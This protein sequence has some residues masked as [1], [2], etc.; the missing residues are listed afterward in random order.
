MSDNPNAARRGCDW[1]DFGNAIS[2]IVVRAPANDVAATLSKKYGGTVEAVD[3]YHTT[4]R[5]PDISRVV[6]QHA[7]HA[8]CVFASTDRDENFIGDLAK[9]LKTRVL[10]LQHED[11]AGWTEFRVFDAGENVETYS[12]G[13]DYADEMETMAEELGEDFQMMP[14]DRGK[15][16]DHRVNDGDGNSFFFRSQMRKINADDITDCTAML[17]DAFVA[18]DAWLPGWSHFPWGDAT[19]STGNDNPQFEKALRIKIR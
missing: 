17:N 6:F 13:P 19:K 3:P 10:A 2:L 1:D 8:H 7:G 5:H 12:F 16:W 15:P 18:A 9:A 11:T 14:D 4:D